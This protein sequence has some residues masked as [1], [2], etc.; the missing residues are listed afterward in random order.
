MKQNHDSC[1]LF[2]FSFYA[3]LFMELITALSRFFLA[4]QRARSTWN[5]GFLLSGTADIDESSCLYVN[6]R[7]ALLLPP[8]GKKQIKNQMEKKSKYDSRKTKKEKKNWIYCS[9]AS[10]WICLCWGLSWYYF[11]G[12]DTAVGKN[13][14][15]RIL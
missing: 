5:S 4:S 14:L 9:I 15:M 1:F 13:G 12:G 11:V 10:R 6:L 3:S 2:S 7:L 8:T